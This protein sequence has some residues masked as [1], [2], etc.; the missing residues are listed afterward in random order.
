MRIDRQDEI[1]ET[2]YLARSEF[3]LGEPFVRGIAITVSD[4]RSDMPIDIRLRVGATGSDAWI[5]LER[6]IGGVH[7]SF[8]IG[9]SERF[10]WLFLLRFA[11]LGLW[12]WDNFRALPFTMDGPTTSVVIHAVDPS[13]DS[14]NRFFVGDTVYSCNRPLR[15]FWRELNRVAHWPIW[16]WKLELLLSKLPSTLAYEH[17]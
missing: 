2:A 5:E 16:R 8:R 1:A 3:S 15:R 12:E 14:Y 6:C 4:T 13:I 10:T 11:R 9:S 7:T 17:R